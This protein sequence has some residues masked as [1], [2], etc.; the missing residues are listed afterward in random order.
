[1]GELI[2]RVPAAHEAASRVFGRG[3]LV[4]LVD[5]NGIFE[6]DLKAFR[7]QKEQRGK[8]EVD[9]FSEKEETALRDELIADWALRIESKKF[10]PRAVGINRELSALH[11]QFA[12]SAHF[13]TALR[14]SGISEGS[15]K[16]ILASTIRGE[17][18]IQGQIVPR[19]AVSREEAEKYFERHQAE[20]TN[21]LRIRARHIFLAAAQGSPPELI[22]AKRRA[23]RDL[24][25]RLSHG[26]DFAQLASAVSED[27]ATKNRGGDLGFFSA[28]RMPREFF[29]A[30]EK[31]PANSPP[32]FVQSHLGFHAVQVMEVRPPRLIPFSEALPEITAAIAAKKR[33]EAIHELRGQFAERFRLIPG[34]L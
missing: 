14:R 22:D 8:N 32:S 34:R 16:Q 3:H 12:D 18:W 4:A 20:F 28:D 1:M 11:S 29:L 6:A 15:L 21:P 9:I 19:L 23:M 7:A 24:I 31:L 13:R 17:E 30:V 33:T 25:A 10:G 27:E 2:A 26:E 5:G